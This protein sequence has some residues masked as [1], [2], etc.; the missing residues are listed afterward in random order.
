LAGAQAA[1]ET[2]E[3][4]KILKIERGEVGDLIL[5]KTRLTYETDREARV[6]NDRRKMWRYYQ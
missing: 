5:K 4:R 3:P 2:G 1:N 6:I